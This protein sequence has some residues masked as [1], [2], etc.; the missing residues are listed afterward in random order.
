MRKLC[1]AVLALPLLSFSGSSSEATS[2]PDA[3]AR[4]RFLLGDW[5][6][7]GSGRPG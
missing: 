2:P 6:G 3:W 1:F 5:V 7:E 4:Y